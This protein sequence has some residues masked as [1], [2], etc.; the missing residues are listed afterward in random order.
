MMEVIK[1]TDQF[2]AL[3]LQI[4][5]FVF[6]LGVLAGTLFGKWWEMR[7]WMEIAG[8]NRTVLYGGWIYRVERNLD[9]SRDGEEA[10]D[11]ETFGISSLELAKSSVD[12]IDRTIE[13][14]WKRNEVQG[15][16]VRGIRRDEAQVTLGGTQ[17]RGIAVAVQGGKDHPSAD[18]HPLGVESWRG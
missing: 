11:G 4:I 10:V 12:G 7:D 9:E 17:V 18:E 3:V 16:S 2:W 15:A 13:P 5:L 8:T 14:W 6:V 1:L